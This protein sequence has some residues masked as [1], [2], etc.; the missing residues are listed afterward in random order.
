MDKVLFETKKHKYI[1]VGFAES[2]EEAGIP[3]N[4]YMIIHENQAILLDPGGFGLFPILISR[5]LKYTNI[6]NISKIILSHQDPDVSGGLNIWLETTNADVYISKLWLRFIPHYDI[7]H[8]DRIIPV[9]D[10]GMDIEISK[11][12]KLRLIPAHFLHSPGQINVYDPVS[13]ILFTGDI[14]AGLLPCSNNELFVK[15]FEEYIPCIED[16]HKRY[17]ASNKALRKWV[18]EVRK[19]DIDI[20]APQHGYLYKGKE[21]D[22]LL[23][24]LYNLKCGVDL[25]E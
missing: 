17:M 16:F 10:E 25:Y 6:E 21:K 2:K 23:E 9:P 3:S 19:L 15:N 8:S 20:I 12:Y 4:Q 24:Y 5:V 14:G 13:K 22:K 11:D 7:E 1:L 18:D